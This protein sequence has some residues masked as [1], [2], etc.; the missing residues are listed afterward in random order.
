MCAVVHELWQLYGLHTSMQVVG[1]FS[2]SLWSVTGAAAKFWYNGNIAYSNHGTGTQ[3][4]QLQYFM[5]CVLCK[6]EV[7]MPSETLQLQS[8]KTSV[9]GMYISPLLIERHIRVG[10]VITSLC[11]GQKRSA[12]EHWFYTRGLQRRAHLVSWDELG[13]IVPAHTQR[14]VRHD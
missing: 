5:M 7:A 11:Y 13:S 10:G 8:E 4:W 3:I 12:A 6:A 9:L 2:I 14:T 1:I